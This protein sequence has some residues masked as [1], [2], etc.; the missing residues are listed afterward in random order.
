MRSL[1]VAPAPLAAAAVVSARRLVGEEEP[2]AKGC[3]KH[4]ARGDEVGAARDQA[5]DGWDVLDGEHL[6]RRPVGHAR[7]VPAEAEAAVGGDREWGEGRHLGAVA[8]QLVQAGGVL[9]R[10]DGDEGLRPL[11]EQQQVERL[12][13]KD[14]LD[15]LRPHG[16]GG[17]GAGQL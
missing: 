13:V 8:S 12:Q 7:A 9:G 3:D 6:R 11:A 15:R 17:G 14:A 1:R 5:A 10:V 2:Y 4:G 16:G